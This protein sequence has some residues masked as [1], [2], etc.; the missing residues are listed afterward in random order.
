M[1]ETET[2]KAEPCLGVIFSTEGEV[3]DAGSVELKGENYTVYPGNQKD[4]PKEFDLTR[5]E[6]MTTANVFIKRS[7]RMCCSWTP[8]GWKCVPC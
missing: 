1:P 4:R 5:I 8:Y 6:H 3:L 2:K 7:S